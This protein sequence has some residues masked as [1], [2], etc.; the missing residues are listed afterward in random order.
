MECAM[1]M[2]LRLVKEFSFF[3]F[4]LKVPRLNLLIEGVKNVWISSHTLI[5]YKHMA[6]KAHEGFFSKKIK[7]IAH[8]DFCWKK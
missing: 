6:N 5:F 8:E 4:S 3:F 7:H 2:E 1:E